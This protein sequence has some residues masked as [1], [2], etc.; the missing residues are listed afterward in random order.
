MLR[1]I[2]KHSPPCQANFGLMILTF[3]AG[4]AGGLS[5][6]RYLVAASAEVRAPR[7]ADIAKVVVLDEREAEQMLVLKILCWLF[8]ICAIG[9]V[10]LIIIPA[11]EDARCDNKGDDANIRQATH[12]VKVV[13]S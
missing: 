1:P 9:A 3:P 10:G 4:S 13:C 6:R 8:L 7:L 2:V 12:S 5:A 11:L